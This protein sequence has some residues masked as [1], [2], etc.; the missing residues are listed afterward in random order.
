MQRTF[1]GHNARITSLAFSGVGDF[2]ASASEDGVVRIRSLKRPR[3][4]LPLPGIGSGA[5]SVVF[6]N[7]GRTLLTGGQDGVIRLWALPGAQL[8]QRN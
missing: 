4:Y 2:L 6:S 5:K 7:D 8:A 1:G 3:N